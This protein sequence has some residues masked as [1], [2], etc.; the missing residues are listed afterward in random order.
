MDPFFIK[1]NHHHFHK[2]KSL[3][4]FIFLNNLVILFNDV[5]K[6]Q[7]QFQFFFI[8]LFLALYI[9][10]T[11]HIRVYIYLYKRTIIFFKS[12]ILIVSS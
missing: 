1:I 12:A 8:L 10:Y 2:L 9:L 4:Y 3:F 6:V 11:I 7:V 5:E